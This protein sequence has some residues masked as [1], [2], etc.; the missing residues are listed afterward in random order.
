MFV[1]SALVPPS[2]FA[3]S[4]QLGGLD[5]IPSIIGATHSLC[6]VDKGATTG[7]PGSPNRWLALHQPQQ[8]MKERMKE[9]QAIKMLHHDSVRGSS[10]VNVVSDPSC[11]RY[12]TIFVQSCL[13]IGSTF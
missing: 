8:D 4:A 11:A 6:R 3:S 10:P 9:N 7:H 2:H 12:V 13:P 5:R 1:V